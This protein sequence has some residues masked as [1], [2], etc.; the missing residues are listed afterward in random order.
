MLIKIK[1]SCN[2]CQL[3]DT[4]CNSILIIKDKEIGIL[5]GVFINGIK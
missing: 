4:E 3:T 1:Y 2:A 5:I